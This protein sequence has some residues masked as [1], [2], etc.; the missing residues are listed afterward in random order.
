MDPA[1][2]VSDIYFKAGDISHDVQQEK[3]AALGFTEGELK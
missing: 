3:M 1:V 2:S